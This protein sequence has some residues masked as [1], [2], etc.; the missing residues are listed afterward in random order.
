MIE[1]DSIGLKIAENSEELFWAEIKESCEKDIKNLEKMLKFQTA[2]FKMAQNNL[3][4][5]KTTKNN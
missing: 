4:D 1:D 5:V 3:D 2:I